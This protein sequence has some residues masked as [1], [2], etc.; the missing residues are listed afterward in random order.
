MRLHLRPGLVAATTI[1][2]AI[3]CSLGV[4]QVQ[5]LQWKRE[6]ISR[7]TDRL[8]ADPIAFDDALAREA[9]GENMEYHPVFIEGVYAHDLESA[10][11]GT[12]EGAAGVYIFTPLDAADPATGGR[13]FVYVNRGFAP[14]DFRDPATRA[15]GEVLGEVR[16]DGLFRR[17]ERKSG[18]EKWLAP[19]DQPAD[20]LYFS[21]DPLVFAARHSIETPGFYIDSFGGERAGSWPKGGLT[22]V[23]L[24]NRHFEYA[25]TWFGLAAALLGVF[26][27]FSVQRR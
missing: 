19:K 25:L 18:F 27:A 1:A 21:R 10:V 16:I 4:W 11:F 13:R 14:Q 3:L 9:A 22:R 2:F 26:I 23:D 20:N 6:L 24:P 17:A 15:D 12:Y 7:M 8:A 5:R